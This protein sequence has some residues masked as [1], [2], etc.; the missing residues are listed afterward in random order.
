MNE[1]MNT[2]DDHVKCYVTL[3]V[4][5]NDNHFGKPSVSFAVQ[6]RRI[7]KTRYNGISAADFIQY[8]C[9]ADSIIERT[10]GNFLPEIGDV[11]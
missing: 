6:L 1:W 2:V 7:I 5:H 4:D 8:Q 3:S 11:N 9:V 10:L